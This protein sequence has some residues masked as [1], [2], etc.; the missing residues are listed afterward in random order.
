[1]MKGNI[2]TVVL[3]SCESPSS[4]HPYTSPSPSSRPHGK[5][6][7]RERA[8]SFIGIFVDLRGL[9][10]GCLGRPRGIGNSKLG[11]TTVFLVGRQ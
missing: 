2:K 1:M 5:A 3:L 4:Y 10:D 11:E 8:A 9:F 6:L 7:F